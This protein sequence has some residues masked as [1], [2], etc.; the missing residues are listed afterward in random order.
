MIK[1]KKNKKINYEL[2]FVLFLLIQPL[3][4]VSYS[5]G[6][7]IFNIPLFINTIIRFIFLGIACFYLL[8]F[9]KE[10]NYKIITITL[11]VYMI[12]F[13]INM[14]CVKDYNALFYEA[15]NLLSTFYFPISLLFFVS[16]FKH[17]DLRITNKN[18]LILIL[19]YVFFIIVPN[20]IGLGF[21]SYAEDKTGLIGWFYSANAVSSILVLLLPLSTL[22]FAQKDKKTYGVLYALI[23]IYIFF[24]IG[25]KTPIFG[26]LLVSGLI[27]V[28]I[29][30]NL[31][32]KKKFSLLVGIFLSG[33]IAIAGLII[34][35]PKTNFY[36]N[37]KTHVSYFNVNSFKDVIQNEELLDQIVFSRRLTFL[38]NTKNNYQKASL[39]EKILGIGYIENYKQKNENRKI[40]EID[41]LD[42]I[43]R[44]GPIGI[45]LYFIPLIM[46]ILSITKKL[47]PL[48]FEKYVYL[49]SIF[50]AFLLALFSGHIFTTPAVSI[51]LVYIISDLN[52]KCGKHEKA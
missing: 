40:I 9:C 32:Q 23:I 43:Y 2:I 47:L 12:I 30:K 10:K 15:K 4:D 31:C 48:T 18:W 52:R 28:W 11:V 1:E 27:I 49:I 35:L 20:V 13:M 24:S 44:H 26:L 39:S 8:F 36:K 6:Y 42:V 25:T 21:N 46:V 37:I 50:L 3:L 17:F 51:I 16:V 45:I 33:L 22:F 5:V 41:Y 7:N 29:I 14:F 34:I 19:M 38:K